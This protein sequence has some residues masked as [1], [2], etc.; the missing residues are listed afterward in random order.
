MT[1]IHPHTTASIAAQI[2]RLDRVA[3][4]LVGAVLAGTIGWGVFTEIDGAVVGA[5]TLIVDGRS[6][7]VQHLTGGRVAE[8]R[9]REG[10]TVAEGDVLVRLDDTTARSQ[11]GVI[12]ARLDEFLAREARLGAELV[13]DDVLRFPADIVARA[14]EAGAAAAMRAEAAMFEAGRAARLGSRVQLQERIVQTRRQ[15]EG[16][17]AQRAAKTS[18][19][20]LMKEESAAVEKLFE[21]HLVGLSRTMPLRRAIASA[22]GELGRIDASTAEARSVV[23]EA[24]LR[25]LQ[26]DKDLRTD[27]ARDLTTLRGQIAEHRE[28]RIAAREDLRN[29]EIR[30]PRAGRVNHLEVHTLGGV[31]KAGDPVLSIV[32]LDEPLVAEARVAPADIDRVRLGA[33]VTVRLEAGNQ[34]TLPTVA[35]TVVRVADETSTDQRTGAPY[36]PIRVEFAADGARLPSDLRLVSGMPLHAFVGTGARSP[37]AYL[38]APLLEQVA[39]AW[40]ER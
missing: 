1:E 10:D 2:R 5:G 18:E 11:L 34:R 40:R 7:T 6:K 17:D 21:Q 26:I 14:Q 13:G 4:L 32:P 16:L 30:S 3:V 33:A 31:I 9:V 22:S 29:T 15:I 28:R 37:V 8:I 20:E 23:A 19:I 35:G 38:F 36:Y 27:T 25:V 24:E 12:D 39:L